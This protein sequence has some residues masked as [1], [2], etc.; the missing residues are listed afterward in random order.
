VVPFSVV[1]SGVE[2]GCAVPLA[3]LA[4]K[5]VASS[6]GTMR[7]PKLAPSVTA[8]MLCPQ[9]TPPNKTRLHTSARIAYK[10]ARKAIAS[11]S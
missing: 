8:L 2:L 5:I 7:G 1:G 10:L 9:A 3:K 11:L 4:P 6:P